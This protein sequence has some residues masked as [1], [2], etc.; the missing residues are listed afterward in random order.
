MSFLTNGFNFFLFFFCIFII[1]KDLFFVFV[2]LI[3]S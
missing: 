3:S 1:Y 2:F